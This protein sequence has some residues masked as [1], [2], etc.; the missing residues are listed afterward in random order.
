MDEVDEL[1]LEQDLLSPTQAS[2]TIKS[3]SAK[4]KSDKSFA[5]MVDADTQNGNKE[6]SPNSKPQGGKT[7]EKLRD[8]TLEKLLNGDYG[9]IVDGAGIK[10]NKEKKAAIKKKLS[11]KL[12]KGTKLSS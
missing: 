2:Q 10:D 11:N 9:G 6:S 12:N 3:M 4:K 5:A 7:Q 1:L 8:S